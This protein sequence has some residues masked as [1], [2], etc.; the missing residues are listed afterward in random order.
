MK[1]VTKIV[2][3]VFALGAVAATIGAIS[4]ARRGKVVQ[5]RIE[6]AESRDL[7]SVV[8]ASGWVRPNRK[9]DVQ[10]D[11]MGRITSL[12]VK[13]GD[14]VK[15]DQVLLRIDPS[16]YE[17]AVERARAAVSESQ[18]REAQTRANLLQANRALDRLRAL[19]ASDST[20]VSRQSL[21]EAETQ[22]SVDTE[23]L[24]AATFSV[25]QARAALGEAQDRLRKTVIRAPMDGMVTRLNVDEGETA[26][27]GT[28]NNAGSLLLTVAD[29]S[30]MEA[31]VRVD[32]TDVPNLS[33]GDSAALTFDAFPKQTF[34]GRITEIS[35]SS[36]RPPESQTASGQGGQGQAIDFE[37]VIAI[38]SPP[39]ALRSDLS[40]TAD[41]V[42]DKRLNVL[43][44]PII[45]LTVRQESDIQEVPQEDPVARAAASAAARNNRPTDIEGIFVVRNG[46]ARFVPVQVGIAGREHFEVLNGIA[47]GDSVIAGPYEAIRSLTNGQKV[48]SMTAEP[49]KGPAAAGPTAGRN[50]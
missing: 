1:R 35:H 31:V 8:N 23:L 14:R 37:V 47:A 11:I 45:A 43:S 24:E 2:I 38:E 7:E 18:A 13:E 27:V 42:T 39:E 9:V 22:V 10:A 3:G 6:A 46:E 15:R 30:I 26:I 29:L 21:E 41:I 12:Q 36:V 19:L 34:W 49:G 32:E 25:A 48:R 4:A 33:V 44:I 17:S 16:E 20:L 40:A 50:P 5:V 28:M